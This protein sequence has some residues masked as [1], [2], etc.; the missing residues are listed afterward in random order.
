[1]QQQDNMAS[2]CGSKKS[3]LA[4][5]VIQKNLRL[6]VSSGDIR[7]YEEIRELTD[8]DVREVVTICDDVFR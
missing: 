5:S 6:T 4:N 7:D 1:M 3:W 8:A 2:I